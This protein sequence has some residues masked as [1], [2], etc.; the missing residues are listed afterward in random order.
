MI[1]NIL[2]YFPE[3]YT[4]RKVQKDVLLEV[5][6]KWDYYDVINLLVDVGGG[7]S[8]ILQTI[9]RW[10]A[11]SGETTATM[12]PRVTLQQQY[13]STFPEVTVLQGKSRYK[14]K[15]TVFRNCLEKKEVTGDYCGGCDYSCDRESA[16]EADNAVFSLHSYLMLRARK[17]NLLLDEAHKVYSIMADQNTI[18]LWQHKVKYPNGMSDYGDVILWLEKAIQLATKEA[19]ELDGQINEMRV[20]GTDYKDMIA[21]VTGYKEI[22]Q[23]IRKYKRVMVGIK[24][25]P[26][27]YFIEHVKEPYRGKVLNALRIRPTT[28]EGSM[29]WLWP[30]PGT[31]KLVLASGT[32]SEQ[33]ISKLGLSGLRIAWIEGDVT[34]KA[35]DRPIKLEFAGNMSYKFQDKAMPKM[36]EKLLVLQARHPETKGIAHAPY[37]VAFKLRKILGN[38]PGIIFHDQK[39]KE[40]AL[41][42]F[43]MS[44]PGTLF[45]ASGMSEGLDLSGPEYGYQAIC[46]T[47][48]PSK[49]DKLV[50]HWYDNDF[51]WVS[52]MTLR[53]I[54]QTCGRVNRYDGDYA[55]TYL[56]D[57]CFGNP[58]RNR[59][60][61]LTQFKS[62]LPKYFLER[63]QE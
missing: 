34:I 52:W 13:K 59:R 12:T 6:K 39:D 27:D 9:A 4:P 22:E 48:W 28:L 63:I 16:I 47:I 29:G 36:A 62:K 44:P 40:E 32:L 23:L 10:R 51:D 21:W 19:E 30:K 15:D 61:F 14:C 42:R 31:K 41:E 24:A 53:D 37:A 35:K 55:I 38:K 43:R 60:G 11:A 1:S 49:A 54:M 46:K 18:Q 45:I 17:D 5:E 33:D 7:K 57:S 8:H 50:A 58:N 26:T 20:A 56:L 3:G 2:D 25:S